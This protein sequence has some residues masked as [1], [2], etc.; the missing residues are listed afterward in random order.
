MTGLASGGREAQGR[1]ERRS[2]RMVLDVDFAL[3][4][5]VADLTAPPATALAIYVS[6][7]VT[8]TFPMP[9]STPRPTA[10][11][12]TAGGGEP[13]QPG[14]SPRRAPGGRA[15]AVRSTA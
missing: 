13:H 5:P 3:E 11:F 15:G 9:T 10:A 6:F 7:A 8:R 4:G 14:P 1:P 2:A 12:G